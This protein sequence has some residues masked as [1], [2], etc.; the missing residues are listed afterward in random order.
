M[1]FYQGRESLPRRF[2]LVLSSALQTPGLPFSDVLTEEDIEQAFDDEQAWFAQEEDDIYTPPVTLWAFLSQVLHKEEQF[3]SS[4]FGKGG[5]SS[6]PTAP[7]SA[8]RIPKRIRTSI[9]NK[10]RRKKESG[11][12]LRGWWYFM[13]ALLLERNVDFVARLHHARKEKTYRVESLVVG[14]TLT[15]LDVFVIL[16]LD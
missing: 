11:F 5:T 16:Q 1:S 15:D 7:R 6:W 12:R 3:P 9:C 13:I 10:H 8:C 14:T 4:G 2:R